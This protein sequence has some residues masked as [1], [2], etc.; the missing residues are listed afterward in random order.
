[1]ALPLSPSAFTGDRWTIEIGERCL[2]IRAI[3]TN[4]PIVCWH[5]LVSQSTETICW[6]L[7]IDSV[8]LN[9]IDKH[10][11]QHTTALLVQ[12]TLASSCTHLRDSQL[13]S[14]VAVRHVLLQHAFDDV[15]ISNRKYMEVLLGLFSDFLDGAWEQG[16]HHPAFPQWHTV[17]HHE[18]G[19]HYT[20]Q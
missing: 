5:W 8:H 17:S 7:C 12:L 6:N 15:Y 1:M 19:K 2:P 4:S 18:T 10:G 16:Y 14:T 20:K 11:R 3:K 13:T 9:W